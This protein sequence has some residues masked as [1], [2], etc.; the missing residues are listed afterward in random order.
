L[1]E[2][3]EGLEEE[4]K[5]TEEEEEVKE[6]GGSISIFVLSDLYVK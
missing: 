1:E 4:E 5:G 3:E 6:V 2:E